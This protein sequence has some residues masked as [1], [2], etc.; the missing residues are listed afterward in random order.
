EPLEGLVPE[1][2]GAGMQLDSARSVDEVEERRLAV[3]AA[4]GQAT[5]DPIAGVRLLARVEVVVRGVDLRDRPD[6]RVRVREGFDALLAQAGQ[7]GPAVLLRAVASASL[8]HRAILR[9]ARDAHGIG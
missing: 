3:A 6:A 7:L 5:R 9:T 4:G 8:G 2:I 1:H